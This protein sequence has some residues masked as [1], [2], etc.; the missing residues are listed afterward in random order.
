MATSLEPAARFGPQGRVR[1][2]FRAFFGL[3]VL[4]VVIA[5]VGLVWARR[6]LEGERRFPP[7][8][9]EVLTLDGQDAGPTR[10]WWI[11]TAHQ[12]MPRSAVLEADRDP[13]PD[14]PYVMA[15]PS[16]VLEWADGRLLLVDTGMT[17]EEAASFGRPLQWLGGAEPMEP[18][19][20]AAARL[21][22]AKARVA[23]V[24]FTHLHTDHTGGLGALCEGGP[25][26]IP[27]FMSTPQAERPNYTTRPG[28]RQVKDASCARILGL[29]DEG[30]MLPVPG[31]PGVAVVPAAGHTPGSQ[32]VLATV[33]DTRYAFA[34]DLA[35]A[36]DGILLNIPKPY[37]YSLLV[38]PEDTAW[39]SS[40]R[41]WLRGLAQEH[42]VVVLPA[43]DQRAIEASG[44]PV[45]P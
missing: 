19:A 10:V 2:F 34:G 5:V 15:H 31:F 39:L 35:N 38:V 42:G 37:L 22:A 17:P 26:E 4:L 11:N 18:L 29:G 43:H 6:S 27:V 25:A 24:I 7:Q 21:G 44:V 1:L 16:F 40:Q 30:G 28:L 41:T 8:A 14:Q 36:L 3:I 9:A 33:G 32:V 45:W 23:G 20:A 12:P 13:T